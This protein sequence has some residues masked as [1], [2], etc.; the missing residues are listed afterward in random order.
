[1]KKVFLMLALFGCLTA[2]HAQNEDYRSTLSLSAGLNGWQ[3]IS[4]VDNISYDE[5]AAT[6]ENFSFTATPSFSFSYDYGITKWFSLGGSASWNRVKVGADR[7]V[8]NLD[9]DN[10]AETYDGPLKVDASRIH[11]GIR[12]LFHYANNG[13]LDLY[14]GLRIGAII[15]S[16]NIDAD[17]ELLPD[18]VLPFLRASGVRPGVQVIPFGLRGYV[19][20]NLGF[21]FELAIGA[22]HFAAAQLNYRFGG[23]GSKR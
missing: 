4:L 18:D 9:S 2:A 23:G 17:K 13:K 21:G 12:P 11:I 6:T 20:D 19:N 22:P 16:G 3:L 1:M 10:N 8:I 5:D 7:I 15:W 14:S